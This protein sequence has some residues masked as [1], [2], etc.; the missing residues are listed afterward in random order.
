MKNMLAICLFLLICVDIV[1]FGQDRIANDVTLAPRVRIEL[2]IGK[3]VYGRREPV[4][5]RALLSN[6]DSSGLYIS[7]SF[8]EAG[9]GIAGFYIH[10]TQLSGKKGGTICEAMAGDAFKSSE[11]RSPE[12]IVREDFLP[13]QPGG[14]V[15]YQAEYHPCTVANPGEYEIWVEYITGDLSQSV[16][17]S[18][19]VNQQRVLDGK[20]KSMPVKFWVR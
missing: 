17:R 12:Q 2:T 7:K 15:G 5:F 13:L 4:K 3:K 20:F 10:G 14:L 16:V 19:V 6:L 9:G 8:Y 11:S 18:L 1:G